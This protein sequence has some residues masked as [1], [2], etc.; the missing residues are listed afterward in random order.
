MPSCW[1]SINQNANLVWRLFCEYLHMSDISTG[2]HGNGLGDL[3][4]INNN[5]L[6]KVNEFQTL[7]YNVVSK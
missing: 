7:T 1:D 6:K 2:A 4:W 5:I 3:T